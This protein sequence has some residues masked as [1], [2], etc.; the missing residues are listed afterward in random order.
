MGFLIFMCGEHKTVNRFV[1]VFPLSRSFRQ[2]AL[3]TR[4]CTFC[5]RWNTISLISFVSTVRMAGT[6]ILRNLY[7]FA[8][9]TVDSTTRHSIDTNVLS[10]WLYRYSAIDIRHPLVKNSPLP[11]CSRKAKARMC[12]ACFFFHS[13]SQSTF[14][15]ISG[16]VLFKITFDIIVS[17]VDFQSIVRFRVVLYSFSC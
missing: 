6:T 4:V 9:C 2:C 16:D 12:C 17:G 15:T 7:T 3:P 1:C 11:L 5:C 10:V 14:F 13:R 8:S